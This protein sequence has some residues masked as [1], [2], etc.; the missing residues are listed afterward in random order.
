ME[1][2]SVMQSAIVNSYYVSQS[3]FVIG[4]FLLAWKQR[5]AL[6]AIAGFGFVLF[7]LA[8]LQMLAESHAI[9][10]AQQLGQSPEAHHAVFQSWRIVSAVGLLAASLGVVGA[11]FKSRRA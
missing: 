8:N 6:F 2:N 9:N 10:E 5:S 3:I 11:A 1:T 4:M 7:L